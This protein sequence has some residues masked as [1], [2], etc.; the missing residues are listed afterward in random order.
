MPSQEN[1]S[2]FSALYTG[3]AHPFWSRKRGPVPWGN[4]ELTSSPEQQK[5]IRASTKSLDTVTVCFPPIKGGLCSEDSLWPCS[6]L[7]KLSGL[8]FLPLALGRKHLS[9]YLWP[10]CRCQLWH[11][12][13]CLPHVTNLPKACC[14]GWCWAQ[15]VTG[16][17][18]LLELGYVN[19]GLGLPVAIFPTK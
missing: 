9:R 15:G 14:S 18:F 16:P 11:P 4:P 19:V 3:P 7:K 10:C 17:L 8:L 12:A 6:D 2:L 13:H 1:K 5:Q